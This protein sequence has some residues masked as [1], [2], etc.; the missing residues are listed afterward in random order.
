[1]GS[2]VEPS[3][4]EPVS[5]RA[6]ASQHGDLLGAVG[7]LQSLL[8]NVE[9][10]DTFLGELARLA[11]DV[12]VP[13]ASCGVTVRRDGRPLTAASSDARA[14]RV[15]QVQYGFGEGPCLHTLSSGEVVD[16]SDLERDDRWPRYRARALEEGVRSSLSL[17]LVV[18][19]EPVG[20]LN[21]YG[22]GVGVLVGER[23]SA[24]AF[25]A[26][27][28]AALTLLLRQTR[29]TEDTAQLEQA[30]A[31]RTTIDQALG[32]LM[33]QQHCTADQ[34]FALLRSHS[35]HNNRKLRDVAADIVA[36]VSG[37]APEPAPPF[38]RRSRLH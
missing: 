7:T 34:A 23:Q 36:R 5:A 28:A 13:P 27:A 26:Q 2:P 12:V 8:L 14:E 38:L 35:Q 3:P 1:M 25:A 33:A 24:Q 22:F 32:I 4:F 15:D 16:V 20:A 18:D 17:P 37:A 29:L 31:S 30:L 6:T 21:L 9:G 11:A 10:V 19:G